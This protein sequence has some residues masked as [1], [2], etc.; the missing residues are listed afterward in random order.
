MRTLIEAGVER[1]GTDAGTRRSGSRITTVRP[2]TQAFLERP[3]E[4]SLERVRARANDSGRWIQ[5]TP[6]R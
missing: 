3:F 1:S 4:E 5:A 6:H 2:T